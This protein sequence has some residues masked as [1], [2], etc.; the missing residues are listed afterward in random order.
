[1]KLVTIP[2]LILAVASALPVVPIP[3]G[4][5]IDTSGAARYPAPPAPVVPSP[6]TGSVRTMDEIVPAAETTAVAAA[7]QTE[8]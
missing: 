8:S 4:R 6:V 2:L 1:M 3:V 7:A 5:D